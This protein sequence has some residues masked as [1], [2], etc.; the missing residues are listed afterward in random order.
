[1]R[2]H[3][4]EKCELIKIIRDKANAGACPPLDMVRFNYIK[5]VSFFILKCHPEL[6]FSDNLGHRIL[7]GINESCLYAYLSRF[8]SP[9]TIFGLTDNS[10]DYL[11]LA[12]TNVATEDAL[13]NNIVQKSHFG[14][15]DEKSKSAHT[16]LFGPLYWTM[17]AEATGIVICKFFCICLL[18]DC[19]DYR[20][21]KNDMFETRVVCSMNQNQFIQVASSVVRVMHCLKDELTRG[22]ELQRW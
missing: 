20:S 16:L 1:M 9:C 4:D 14:K 11:G 7:S 17:C 3:F 10:L 5:H 6:R 22:R 2:V 8:Y 15:F 12:Y 18:I 19:L 13:G 21:I